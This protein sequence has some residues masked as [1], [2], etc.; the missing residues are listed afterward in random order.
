MIDKVNFS[1]L[2]PQNLGYSILLDL[3]GFGSFLMFFHHLRL[4]SQIGFAIKSM[5][6][7]DVDGK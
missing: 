2:A 1:I 6:F 3:L 4:F 5:E 7:M